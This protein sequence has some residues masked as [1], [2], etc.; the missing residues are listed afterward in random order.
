MTGGHTCRTNLAEQDHVGLDIF[1]RAR[2]QTAG[3]ANARLHLVGHKQGVVGLAELLGPAEVSG[4]LAVR[5]GP[6]VDRQVH[7]LE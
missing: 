2:Q 1:V 6:I 7:D 4:M 5:L 3:A